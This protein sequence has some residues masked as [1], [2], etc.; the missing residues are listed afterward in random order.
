MTLPPS[1]ISQP[2][3]TLGAEFDGPF[4]RIPEGWFNMG[5]DD[6]PEDE[7]PVHPVWVDAFEVA[8]YPV[9]CA[10]L[11]TF[12]RAPS[13]E[14]PR[15]WR[16]FATA[17]NLPVVGVSWFD[18]QAY[19][20]WRTAIAG[21][22]SGTLRLPTEAEWERAARGGLDGQRYPWG[23]DTPLWIPDGARGPLAGPWSVTLGEPNGFC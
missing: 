21:K 19:C 16:L 18:C 7:R 23:N 6:G 17:P 13:H 14:P 4:V 22:P 5:C 20:G 10:Q 8:I 12:L 11:E 1:A 9:T 2:D 15:D 3:A